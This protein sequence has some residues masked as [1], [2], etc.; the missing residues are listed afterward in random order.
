MKNRQSKKRLV[1]EWLN[2]RF[3][4]FYT[5]DKSLYSG[6]TRYQDIEIVKAGEFGRTL[7]LDNITQV[8]EKNEYHYHE[9]MTH[10]A[11]CGHRRPRDVLVIG[12]GDGGILREVLKYPTVRTVTLAELDAGVIAVSARYLSRVN[13]DVFRDPRVRVEIADGRR[14]VEA[15]PGRFD[16]VIMDVTDPFGN[17]KMLYTREFFRAVRRSFRDR[18]GVFS[19][20]GESPVTRPEAYNCIQKTLR[21]VFHSISTMYVYIQMYATLWS[22]DVC[23]DTTDLCAMRARTIDRKLSTYGIRG[24][25]M[26]SG[27]TLEAMLVEFP[28]LTDIRR[29]GRGRIITDDKPDFPDKFRQVRIS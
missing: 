11:M 21:T 28:Y 14:Y 7:R 12:A 6:R 17:S 4:F 13:R 20:H 26:F 3:G 15:N 24:L 16:V 25:K 1:A 18:G 22:I 29:Q 27:R 2:A 9:P 23:S 8:V 19:M 10:A 5:V